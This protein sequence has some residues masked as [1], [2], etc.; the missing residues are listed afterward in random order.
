MST[1]YIFVA[2]DRASAFEFLSLVTLFGLLPAGLTYAH[3]PVDEP[4]G[5]AVTFEADDVRVDLLQKVARSLG[6]KSALRIAH[7]LVPRVNV[8]PTSQGGVS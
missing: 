5:V 6:Y 7:T 2:D 4:A 3:Q 1:P 8:P